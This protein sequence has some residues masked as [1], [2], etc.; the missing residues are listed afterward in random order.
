MVSFEEL[1]IEKNLVLLSSFVTVL[2]K[3]NGTFLP[4]LVDLSESGS[5]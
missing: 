5:P 1:H 2:R 3:L 4:E